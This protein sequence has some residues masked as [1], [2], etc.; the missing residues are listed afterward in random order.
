MWVLW[1]VVTGRKKIGSGRLVPVRPRYPLE[2]DISNMEKEAENS[3]NAK[4]VI[5]PIQA[6][7]TGNR[8]ALQTHTGPG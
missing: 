6:N 7:V 3:E 8:E 2:I 5:K 4:I 1:A